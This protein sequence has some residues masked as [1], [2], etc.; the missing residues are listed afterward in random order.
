MLDGPADGTPE[1]LQLKLPTDFKA[2]VLVGIFSLMFL[3]ALYMTGE[4]SDS[5]TSVG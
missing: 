2:L 4:M 5:D 1:P 3:Y